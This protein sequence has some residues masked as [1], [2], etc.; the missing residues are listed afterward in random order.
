MD[1]HHLLQL[2]TSSNAKS[3]VP[4]VIDLNETPPL[5]SP[6]AGDDTHATPFS[7]PPQPPPAVSGGA[8]SSGRGKHV[9]FDINALPSEAEGLEEED[10]N[11]HFFNSRMHTMRD[12]SS[13]I[14]NSNDTQVTCTNLLFTGSHFELMKPP[15]S[16]SSVVRSGHVEIVQQ[17]FNLDPP[18]SVLGRHWS[19]ECPSLTS[20]LLQAQSEFFLQNLKQFVLDKHGVLE[21]GWRVEFYYCPRR[22]KTLAVYCSPDGS[23]FDSILDAAS[24]LGLVEKFHF[25]RA[26]D[27]YDGFASAQNGLHLLTVKNDSLSNSRNNFFKES[28]ENSKSSFAGK[29][30]V[31][32]VDA[33]ACKLRS[34]ITVEQT[35]SEQIEFYGSYNCKDGFPVQFED[36]SVISVGEIDLR[37][38]YHCTSRIW[39]VGYKSS[40]HDKITGSLF[41]CDVSDG[42]DCSP[43]FKVH[44]Y[45]C[46]T[47]PFPTG[48][49][50]LYRPSLGTDN[51]KTNSTIDIDNNEDIDV[52]MILSDHSPSLLDFIGA[53]TSLDEVSNSQ[54]ADDLSKKLNGISCIGKPAST[55]RRIGDDIGEFL[56]EGRSSSSVWTM[57]AQKFAQ[58]CREVYKRTGVC[59]FCCRHAYDWWSSGLVHENL[60]ASES[61]DSLAKFC[62]L[63]GPFNVQHRIESND[64][65]IT[66]CEVLVEWLG[67][68]R[69]GLDIDF[70]QEIIE[71]LPGADSCSSYTFLNKRRDGSNLQ[72]IQNGFFLAKRKDGVQGEKETFSMLK[73]CKSPKKQQSKDSCPPGKPLSSKLPTVLVGDVLQS[74]ELFWRFSEVL[75]LDRPL[76]FKELEEE[77]ID[78]HS[79]TVSSRSASKVTG[80]SQ[81]ELD[82]LETSDAG[83]K[84]RDEPEMH[85]S[86]SG[87]TLYNAHCSLLKVLLAEL[88]SKLAVFVDPSLESAESRSRKRRK[89]EADSLNFARKSML[90]LLPINELTW[91]ELARRYLLTVASMES[92]LDSSEVVTRESCKVFYCLQG[93]SEALHGSLPGVASME[94]DALLLAE[95]TKQIFGTSKVANDS[96]NVD[97]NDSFDAIS[98]REVAL[99][100]S[101]APEWAKVLEPV[102]KLP[103]NVGA[104]IRRCIYDALDLKPPE[105]ATKILKYSISKEVYKGNASGPTKKAVLSVL[106]NVC[107]EPP[108]QKPNRKKKSKHINTLSDVIMKQCRKVLR[109]A[110]AADEEKVFCN[111]LGRTLL[112]ASDNDDEGLLGF[113]TM[114]SRPL[115]FRTIDLRLAFGA[116]GGSHEAF[117]ED[118]REVWHHINTAYADQSELVDLAETLSQKF[119]ALYEEEVLTLVQ[120]LT[121]YATI[122]CPSSEAKKEMEDILEHANEMPKAP[123]DEGVCKVCGVD[124]DDDNVLLCDKCDSGYH[125]YCLNPPLARIP[126]GNWY[127]PS[128]SG[129]GASQVP[130]FIS[131]YRKKRHRGEFTCGIMETLAHL[132]TTMEITDY[133]DYSVE[134]K[135]FLLK[136]LGDEVLDS[137]NIREHLDQCASVSVDLQQK[138]RSLSAEWRNLKL[139]EEIFAE[140]VAKTGILNGTGKFGKEGTAGV[141]PNYVKSM[142]QPHNISCVRSISAIDLTH[143]EE[144]IHKINDFPKQSISNGS[145]FVRVPESECQ[146]NQPDVNELPASNVEAVLIKNRTSVLQDTVTHLESQLQKAS[147]RKEIL[148][149]DSAGRLY[150]AFS[151]PGAFPW[152]VIDGTS[153]VQHKSIVEEHMNLSPS[154]LTLESSLIGP[155]DLSK[156]KGSNVLSPFANDLNNSIAV[157]FQWFSHQSEAEIEGLIKWLRDNDPVQRE[158][159]ESLL[160]RLRFGYN[161]SVATNCIPDVMQ[162]TS[163]PLNSEKT[164]KSNALETKALIALE[165]KY[166]PCTDP[167]ATNISVMLNRDRDATSDNK[168]FRCECLE[169]I[170]PSRHHCRSCH[171]SFSSKC[172]LDEHNDGKCSSGAHARKNTRAVEDVSKRKAIIGIENGERSGK[173][174]QYK[175]SGAGHEIKFDLVGCGNDFTTP[176]SLEEIS[177]K[178]IT[179]SS[180]KELV[181]EIGLLGSNGIPS[182]VPCASPYLS[183]PT[184][185]LMLTWKNEIS[186]NNQSPNVESRLLESDRKTDRKQFSKSNSA[187]NRNAVDIYEELQEIGRSYLMSDKKYQTSLKFNSSKQAN[188]VSG[189]RGS[190]LRPLVGKGAQILRQLK[191]NLLDMDAALPEE[192]LKSSNGCLKKRC[193]WRAFVK[194]AKSI[195]EMV[196]ATI[197]FEYMIK[198]DYLRNGW[199]Y[200]S[201]LSAAAKIA[202][203]SS[204]ALRIYTL[205]AA[206]LYEKTVQ[207]S[208]PKDI[209]QVSSKSD[210]NSPPHTDL[211]N[212]PK[213]GS[214]PAQRNH[215]PE[216]TDNSK[217][218][219]KSGKKRKDSGGG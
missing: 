93:D 126:E 5:S 164:K 204:L 50:V 119:E 147:L 139:K 28:Q 29:F 149:K 81:H 95:A 148:G 177:A 31:G 4:F 175:S 24:H 124:K 80:E 151:R 184:L 16:V 79:S 189:I 110:A 136:F 181:K 169:P 73:G 6:L 23:R 192:A 154:N 162:P 217:P 86:C 134:E 207:P 105:W 178:F 132:G 197:V 76:S 84:M 77:L 113:P 59:K 143:L 133:W 209:A 161:S 71:Q 65:L 35:E 53:A 41:V 40:W 66:T 125:T 106:A 114:V 3:S 213:P 103:T 21:E 118:V 18:R 152:V 72:T 83:A 52:Q 150:W 186:Q 205:D 128:C 42:G 61:P 176:Y 8:S 49:T 85:Y 62:H 173:T 60:E 203:I 100:D 27:K 166:G 63:S 2:N 202:T 51:K 215:N 195:F 142:G 160:Q 64:D 182:L 155:D 48:S 112:N 44:R 74:W 137:A 131:H 108:P 158:L 33:E 190:S 20:S 115:D 141:L 168:M 69:F 36:F 198:T 26:R 187:K 55:D 1:D 163:T 179:R 12:T 92:N 7:C 58:S 111:L 57:V 201:S 196:Q 45:P 102:R 211:E 183:D 78:C 43:V 116:Y 54:P 98:G 214:K 13:S 167:D 206:I 104:R 25:S 172:E 159:I 109:L 135:I 185:K 140:K 127:C 188:P 88:Q 30:S 194:Y 68:D 91:P 212:N 94:A 17:R 96:L 97:P 15:S 216:P 129:Q 210:N 144:Q 37:P 219:S 56:V 153:A 191:I 121:D 46:S 11:S 199:W 34:N 117:L 145:Q 87:E 208:S 32:T 122:E 180:N 75:G 82:E 120:K 39:P 157:S 130:Q 101:E 174:R 156:S 218:P 165:K 38:S 123:W 99:K 67:Q 146:V 90:D 89:K 200:W 171:F 22:C 138:L 70:V 10:E 19:S 193:T 9:F 47:K 107:G 170:W 14:G